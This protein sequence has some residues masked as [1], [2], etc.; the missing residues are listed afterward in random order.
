MSQ[1]D[2]VFRH[3]KR[4]G[5]ITPIEALRQ[6]HCMRLARCI[7]DLREAGHGIETVMVTRRRRGRTTRFAEYRY[8]ARA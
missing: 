4:Y 3:L 8:H 7:H 6:Y 5:A 2:L 1:N